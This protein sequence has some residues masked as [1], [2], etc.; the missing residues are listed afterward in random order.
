ML[1][2]WRKGSILSLMVVMLFIFT[3]CAKGNAHVTVKKN[4]S[5]E[6]AMK[7]RLDSRTESMVSSKMDSL[8]TKLQ[9]AG[10]QLQESKVG[11]STEYQYT[12]TYTSQ[13][14][15]SLMV[16]QS[17]EY[18]DANIKSTDKWL[19]TQY[20]IET[21]LHLNT[22]SDKIVQEIDS[23][24]LPKPLIRLLMKSFSFDFSLTLP[25]NLYGANN[26]AV[27]EGKT[28]T[29][30]ITLAD[31]NPIRMV[32]YVPNLKNIAIVAGSVV[33]IITAIMIVWVKRKRR[34]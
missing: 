29:W 24:N 10:I 27:Q 21:Q 30:H 31:S 32:I 1:L 11:R 17:S 20:S 2:N 9:S 7:L 34:A 8:I 18:V 25:F 3:G 4:G 6:V 13:E 33:V 22:Y 12:R 28:L 19:Y 23:V 16:H 15:R 14:L 26:A 5:V